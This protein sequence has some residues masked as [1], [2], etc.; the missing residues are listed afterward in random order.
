MPAMLL[1]AFVQML[2]RLEAE[3]AVSRANATALGSGSMS[4][5]TAAEYT[6]GL[7]RMMNRPKPTPN[8]A[9]P[10]QA[11]MAMGIPIKRGDG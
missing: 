5:E 9:T 4:K 8:Y 6:E 10:M 2:P 1:G 11:A 3:E 7:E